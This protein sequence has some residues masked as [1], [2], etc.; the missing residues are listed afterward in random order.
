MAVN[1]WIAVVLNKKSH[2]HPELR[3]LHSEYIKTKKMIQIIA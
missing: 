1:M 2:N 3:L